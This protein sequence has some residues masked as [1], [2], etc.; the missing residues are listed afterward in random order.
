MNALPRQYLLSLQL[1]QLVVLT[2]T[3][4]RCNIIIQVSANSATC[5]P[6]HLLRTNIDRSFVDSPARAARSSPTAGPG[7]HAA[8]T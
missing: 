4:R 2:L 5:A 8:I 6:V 1:A 3:G 7:C